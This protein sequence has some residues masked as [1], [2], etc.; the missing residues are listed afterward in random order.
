MHTSDN[1]KGYSTIDPYYL[2]WLDDC[3]GGSF[4]NL[5]VN[6]TTTISYLLS[7]VVPGSTCRFRMNTLNIIGYS[8]TFSQVLSVLFAVEP[9]A[10]PT[11]KYVARHGGDA[12]IGLVPYITI[13]WEEPVSDGSAPILGY[14]VE[15]S[16]NGGPWQLIFD[17]S[18]DPETK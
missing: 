9:D 4:S 11:P 12:T 1:D 10:P 17:A 14:F 3:N 5:L 8:T 15:T 18:S 6:S 13:S 2:L 16:I 7:N